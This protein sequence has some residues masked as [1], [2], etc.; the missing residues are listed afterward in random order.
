MS[1]VS[2]VEILFLLRFTAFVHTIYYSDQR[3][4]TACL[5]TSRIILFSEQVFKL[6]GKFNNKKSI[7]SI[8]GEAQSNVNR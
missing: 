8:V 3:K 7:R 5:S 1:I 6:N 2:R 4:N